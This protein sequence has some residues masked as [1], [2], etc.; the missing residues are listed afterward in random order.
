MIPVTLA[1][2]KCGRTLEVFAA[3]VRFSGVISVMI[4]HLRDIG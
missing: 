2:G 1:E 3:E 4:R